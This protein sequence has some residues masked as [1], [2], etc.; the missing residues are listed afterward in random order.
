MVKVE[1]TIGPN[2]VT[3]TEV[4]VTF[5]KVEIHFWFCF[6]LFCFDTGTVVPKSL[7]HNMF[8][9]FYFDVY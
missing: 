3:V 6:C 4:T 7:V 8:I 2:G 1:L 5:P 9:Y